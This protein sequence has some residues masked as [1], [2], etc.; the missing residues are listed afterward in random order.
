M[1]GKIASAPPLASRQDTSTALVE[2]R[3]ERLVEWAAIRA[4]LSFEPSKRLVLAAS[5]SLLK[6]AG[7]HRR[8]TSGQDPGPTW[9]LAGFQAGTCSAYV[10]CS[11][12]ALCHRRPPSVTSITE[13]ASW[14]TLEPLNRTAREGSISKNALILIQATLPSCRLERY[15]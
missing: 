7:R 14:Q 11:S 10:R 2:G 13:A 3:H 1:D 8:Q 15:I 12:C 9:I 4:V 6:R 5:N